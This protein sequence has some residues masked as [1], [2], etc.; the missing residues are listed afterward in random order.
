MKVYTY[1]IVK[2]INKNIDSNLKIYTNL[3]M[4]IYSNKDIIENME[5]VH[6]DLNEQLEIER[7][8]RDIL[9]SHINYDKYIMSSCLITSDGTG[10]MDGQEFPDIGERLRLLEKE[11]QKGAGRVRWVPSEKLKSSFG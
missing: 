1:Q 8:L 10:Y 11:S 4:Q 6:K 3:T 9:R 5:K 7:T 2:E